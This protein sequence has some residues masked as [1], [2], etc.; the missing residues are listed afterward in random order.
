MCNKKNFTCNDRM[1]TL[2]HYC[3]QRFETKYMMSELLLYYG[4]STF[5]QHFGDVF[6]CWATETLII[7]GEGLTQERWHILVANTLQLWDQSKPYIYS[8]VQSE[9]PN[10]VWGSLEQNKSTIQWE[11]FFYTSVWINGLLMN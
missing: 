9:P 2:A 5:T 10:V 7:K 8:D 3:K 11:S 4:N 1:Y 6:A